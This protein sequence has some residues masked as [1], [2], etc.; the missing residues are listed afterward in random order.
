MGK[1]TPPRQPSSERQRGHGGFGKFFHGES[2][3]AAMH[4]KHLAGKGVY[5]YNVVGIAVANVTW[6]AATATATPA[7]GGQRRARPREFVVV[8]IGQSGHLQGR[9]IQ[10]VRSMS[11]WR[12]A[13]THP[14]LPLEGEW[15]DESALAQAAEISRRRW[16]GRL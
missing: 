10:E 4:R 16:I 7:P 14:M 11:R 2:G 1:T 15:G 12:G 6:T 8:K 5:C 3:A 9:L 13:K